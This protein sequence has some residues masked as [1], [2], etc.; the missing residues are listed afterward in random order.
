[1]ACPIAFMDA[2]TMA[3]SSASFAM[4]TV[5]QPMVM[6]LNAATELVFENILCLAS[7]L[8]RLTYHP[9]FL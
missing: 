8:A 6:G 9:V 3:R 7:S 4:V 1:M 2:V 5:A